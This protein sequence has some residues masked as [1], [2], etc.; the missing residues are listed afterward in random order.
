M[1]GLDSSRIVRRKTVSTW[2]EKLTFVAISGP[3]TR[4][5]DTRTP[6]IDCVLGT[7]KWPPRASDNARPKTPGLAIT[8]S[9][10]NVVT[11][12]CA[13]DLATGFT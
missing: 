10:G 6:R 3:R 2:P 4:C 9:R 12:N 11:A 5:V 1:V 7:W 13:M 8:A